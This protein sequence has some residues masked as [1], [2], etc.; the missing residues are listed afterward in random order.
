M[1]VWVLTGDK[2]E[3]AINIGHS[4]GL[5]QHE[6][7]VQVV[8]IQS[9]EL[10]LKEYQKL[11]SIVENKGTSGVALVITGYTLQVLLEQQTIQL[12]QL[13]YKL[14]SVVV[15]RSTPKQKKTVI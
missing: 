11:N 5:I 14:D 4:S 1:K 2:T 12:L 6:Q 8:D 10:F 13:A 15:S 7:I 9:P 3:T